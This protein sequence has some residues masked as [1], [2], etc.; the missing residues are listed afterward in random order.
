[1]AMTL[2]P[3]S[4]RLTVVLVVA[5]VGALVFVM[6]GGGGKK[7]SGGGP[8]APTA[9][10]LA[11]AT[12]AAQALADFAVPEPNAA[13]QPPNPGPADTTFGANPFLSLGSEG[14]DGGGFSRGDVD[15]PDDAG[16]G[17]AD[18]E[19]L[20]STAAAPHRLQ[21]TAVGNGRSLA[22]IDGH[23]VSAG[24][25]VAGW[26]VEYIGPRE[27]RLSKDGRTLTLKVGRD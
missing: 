5:L 14:A 1:M 10:P 7:R 25:F 26:K 2:M 11:A 6:T 15:D 18:A 3:K 17:S 27:A 16:D 8:A 20:N 22:L 19:G 9:A 13:A 24:Q 23:Y 21:G 12:Q 4:P